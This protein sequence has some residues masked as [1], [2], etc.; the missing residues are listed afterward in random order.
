MLP[1]ELEIEANVR[2][3][4]RILAPF[5]VVSNHMVFNFDETDLKTSLMSSIAALTQATE[6]FNF[7]SLRENDEDDLEH[8]VGN[9]MP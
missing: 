8:A 1:A 6:F 5:L 7:S 9:V 3:A 2:E 4:A